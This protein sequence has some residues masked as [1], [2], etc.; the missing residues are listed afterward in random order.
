MCRAV[1]GL[2]LWI[3]LLLAA[4]GDN[5]ATP[6]VSPGIVL[7]NNTPIAPLSLTTCSQ[8][9]V[10][11][12]PAGKVTPTSNP[13]NGLRVKIPP[14]YRP[15]TSSTFPYAL[16]YPENWSVREN[17]TQGNIKGDL[18]IGEKT[19]NTVAAITV[20]S[21]K[22][23]EPNQDSNSYFQAKLKE[24][25]A[26]QNLVYEKQV[27]R[28]VGG[29]TASGIAYNTPDSQPFPY[30]VQTLQLTFT[31]AARGWVVSFTATPAQSNQYCAAFVKILD[32]WAFTGLVK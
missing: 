7:V 16:A 28:N 3:C 10:N 19:N 30:P 23:T 18:L 22:L 17:Q 1:L 31:A 6:A 20:V 8:A 25:S 9:A 21:E 13:S 5:T 26:G 11:A 15:F 24:I 32:S 14:G 27:E 2:L 29:T 4:C 12:T